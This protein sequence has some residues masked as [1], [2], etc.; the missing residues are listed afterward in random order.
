MFSRKETSKTAVQLKC[1]A[2]SGTMEP[3]EWRGIETD[4]CGSCKGIWFDYGE[5]KAIE[6]ADDLPNIDPVFEGEYEE[7]CV[8]EA[9]ADPD[10]HCPLHGLTLER[11]EWY[12]DSKIV[13]DS[14]PECHGIFLDAGE[15]EGY[16]WHLEDV[17]R[18]PGTLT[19]A[20]KAELELKHDLRK[21]EV[22]A[23]ISGVDWGLLEGV[24]TFV[25]KHF[26]GVGKDTNVPFKKN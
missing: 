17:Q 9:M 1:P 4:I 8:K 25:E 15:L 10:R 16:V 11:Y 2:C 21:A 7:R 24:M 12:F 20:M 14:C 5:M 22:D 3:F 23:F 13:M 19:P 6:E 18:N 26:M